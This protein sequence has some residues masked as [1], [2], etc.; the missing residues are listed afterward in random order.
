VLQRG[1]ISGDAWAW[2]ELTH[3]FRLIKVSG[4]YSSLT[5]W[6]CNKV[7]TFIYNLLYIWILH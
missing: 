7:K 2:D 6:V 3:S 5:A 1:G 4:L